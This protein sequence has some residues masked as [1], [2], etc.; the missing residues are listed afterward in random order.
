MKPS[1]RYGEFLQ[2][3]GF[4]KDPVQQHAVYLLDRLHHD[5]LARYYKKD[6]L[7]TRLKKA[8]NKTN[9]NIQGL[10]FWGGVGRG[11]TFIMDIF[12]ETLPISRKKRIH[13]HQFMKQIHDQLSVAKDRKDPLKE[14]A[15]TIALDTEV[16]CLDEF[17]VTDIGDAMLVGRLLEALFDQNMILVTTSNRPPQEL[18]KDGLQ[19]ARFLPA[20]DLLLNNCL[21]SELDGG[22]DFRSLVLRQTNLYQIPHDKNAVT[23]IREYLDTHLVSIHMKEAININDRD[24]NFE[25]CAEATIWFSF[26]VL[27]KTA[28]SRFDYLEI[29]CLFNT[30]VLSDIEVMS[31]ESKDVTSRFITLIDVLYDHGVKLLC[32]AAVP[33]EDLYQGKSLAFEFQRTISRLHEMQGEEYISKSHVV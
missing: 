21:V 32:T 6:N 33:V 15:Q 22:V 17:V 20:I 29:A 4:H 11:K 8:I 2:Q 9:D 7:V 1:T 24:I 3:A 19:R 5:I 30:L 12:Y 18:Y 23:A 26:Q 16:L 10:Y 27:C 13:F 25:Y 14:I 31:D 28:R